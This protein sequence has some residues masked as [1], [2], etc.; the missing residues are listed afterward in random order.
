MSNNIDDFWN[1]VAVLQTIAGTGI[2]VK[3]KEYKEYENDER[4][5]GSL[6]ENKSSSNR[7]KK[8]KNK[9]NSKTQ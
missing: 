4:T 7:T 1:E 9:C 8:E 2:S 6:V 5:L 3:T